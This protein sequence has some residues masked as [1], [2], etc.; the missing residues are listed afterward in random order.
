MLS[1]AL[2]CYG[3][4]TGIAFVSLFSGQKRTQHMASV[5]MMAGFVAHTFFIGTICVRTGHPPLTNLPEAAAF[6]SWTI[7]LVELALYIRYHVYAATFFVYPLAFLLLLTTAVVGEPFALLDPSLRS[8]LFT[9][10]LLLTS[11][12]VAGLFIGLAFTLLAYVQDRSLKS[13]TRG[14]LW[15]WIPSVKICRL[16]G[17][18]ALAAGF[19]IY[20][21]GLMAGVTWSYRLPS[22]PAD[23]RVKQI[24]AAVAWVLFALLLRSQMAGAFS[25]R[26]IVALSAGAFAAIVISILGIAHV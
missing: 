8:S 2:A 23:L 22:G 12:G 1:I 17:Y 3:V 9:A 4:G 15:D 7:L 18:R 20:T 11:V 6:I 26:R 10:H 5:V 19:A 16:V 21:F 13:K 14:R 24:A 25:S